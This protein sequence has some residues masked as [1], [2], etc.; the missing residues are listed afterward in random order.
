[1]GGEISGVGSISMA[2]QSLTAPLLDALRNCR[3]CLL[4]WHANLATATIDALGDRLTHRERWDIG[5]ESARGFIE[6]LFSNEAER[7]EPVTN[8]EV[9]GGVFSG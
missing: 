7:P 6:L 8:D 9:S 1:M 5:Q 3:G 4:A 2:E